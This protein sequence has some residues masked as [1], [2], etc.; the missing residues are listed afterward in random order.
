MDVSGQQGGNDGPQAD[1]WLIESNKPGG[2]PQKLTHF[3]SRIHDICFA[4]DDAL[5]CVVSDLGGAHYD[6]WRVPLDDSEHG[7]TKMTFGQADETRPSVSR[8]GR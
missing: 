7:A 8:D 6:L 3:P 2:K 1:I 4:A 5:L